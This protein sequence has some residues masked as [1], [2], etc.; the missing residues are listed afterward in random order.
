MKDRVE[1]TVKDGTVGTILEVGAEELVETPI[2]G[3]ASR[4][5]WY[6]GRR[7]VA[8]I[9]ARSASMA[10]LS[11]DF[12]VPTGIPRVAAASARERSR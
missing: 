1:L 11:R 12:I 2:D 6:P 3:H 5:A 8:S 9:D 4:S 10:R 7:S